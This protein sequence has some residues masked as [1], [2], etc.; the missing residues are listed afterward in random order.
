MITDGNAEPNRKL[1]KRVSFENTEKDSTLDGT[2]GA[3]IR[4]EESDNEATP[5]AQ[6]GNGAVGP[7]RNNVLQAVPEDRESHQTSSKET[8]TDPRP[9]LPLGDYYMKPSRHEIAK[10]SPEQ[11][12]AF[13]GLII[14]REGCG[15]VT[16]DG[17][18]DL[19]TIDFDNLFDKIVVIVARS[20]TVYPN[21]NEKPPVGKGLNVPSTILL[22]NSWPRSSGT[23]K[24]IPETSGPRYERHLRRL[25]QMENTHFISYDTEKGWWKFTVDHYTQYG[26]DYDDDGDETMDQSELSPPPTSIDKSADAS[27]ME[28]DDQYSDNGSDDEDDTFAFKKSI[29]GQFGQQNVI[30]A[31][32]DLPK[33]DVQEIHSQQ[34]DRSEHSAYSEDDSMSEAEQSPS[35]PGSLPHAQAPLLSSPTAPTKVVRP[36]TPGKPLLDLEGDWADQLQRTISPR[37]QNRDI[38]RDGQNKILLNKIYSPIKPKPA[39]QVNF[40]SSIDI[41]NS[42]FEPATGR[43]ATKGAEPDFEV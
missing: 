2:T 7:S 24:F 30:D 16:F 38:L 23:K 3:L 33:D 6:S 39:P 42:M 31:D 14:G 19:N 21:K 41:M 1:N 28:V 12:K 34:D 11:C 20:I 35:M 17:A 13:R 5:P 27:V 18:V 36:G 8:S 40:R 10:M 25:K 37:K 29:P 43:K 4:T 15:F 32:D 22:Y 26:L 9:D